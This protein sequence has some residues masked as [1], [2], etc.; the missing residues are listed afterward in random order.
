MPVAACAAALVVPAVM[1][2]SLADVA[3]SPPRFAAGGASARLCTAAMGAICV[4]VSPVVSP[5][6]SVFGGEP[7]IVSRYHGLAAQGERVEECR[8][9]THSA[10]QDRR[11]R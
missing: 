6:G 5:T 3:P 9:P 4:S 1:A 2:G 7:F 8:G 10:E 11:R